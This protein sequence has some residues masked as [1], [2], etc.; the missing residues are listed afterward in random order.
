[1]CVCEHVCVRERARARERERTRV[2]DPAGLK[3]EALSLSPNLVKRVRAT[4]S[5]TTLAMILRIMS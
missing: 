3:R 5:P 1:V 4:G 2:E